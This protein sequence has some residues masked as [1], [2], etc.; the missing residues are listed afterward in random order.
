MEVEFLSGFVVGQASL[1][2][3]LYLL[4]KFFLFRDSEETLR[5][6]K[7]LLAGRNKSVLAH[8][9]SYKQTT[10]STDISLTISPSPLDYQ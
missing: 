2:F 8:A 6:K 7:R 1:L 5:E 3:L 9:A 4:C 10:L